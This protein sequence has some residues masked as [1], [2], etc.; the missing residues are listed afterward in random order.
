MEMMVGATNCTHQIYRTKK[1][2]L[3]VRQKG[4]GK[5]PIK[6]KGII[7]ELNFRAVLG[8]RQGNAVGSPKS[9]GD[10]QRKERALSELRWDGPILD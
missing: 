3:L 4:R 5:E 8:K 10:R 1:G 7:C 9:E 2:S 6:N